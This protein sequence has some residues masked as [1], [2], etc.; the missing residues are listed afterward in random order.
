MG[1]FDFLESAGK[2]VGKFF[3]LANEVTKLG[4]EIDTPEISHDNGVVTVSGKVKSQ[5]DREKVILAL[6]N[7]EGVN[8]VIDSLEVMNPEEEADFYTVKPGDS[9]SK[10]AKECYG[11]AMKYMEIFEANKPLLEAPEKI[12]PGQVLRIPKA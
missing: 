3:D 11:N 1:I 12:Y 6:G 10:I 2:K 8:Q 4:I 7:V 5:E 9:L